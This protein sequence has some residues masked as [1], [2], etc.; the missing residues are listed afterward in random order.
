MADDP[1]GGE[2]LKGASFELVQANA[3]PRH[4]GIAGIA[5]HIDDRL[6]AATIVQ[7]IGDQVMDALPAHVGEV[8]R[9][10]GRMLLVPR[11]TR[12]LLVPQLGTFRSDCVRLPLPGRA[13]HRR[14]LLMRS[15]PGPL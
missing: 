8:H 11:R 1:V 3:K 9:R 10:A 13:R 6:V 5:R 7:A 15:D 4:L 12:H 14:L 2:Q